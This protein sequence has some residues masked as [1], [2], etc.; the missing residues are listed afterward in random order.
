MITGT[1]A[2]GFEYSVNPGIVYDAKYIKA[3][4]KLRDKKSDDNARAE[5]VFSMIDAVFSNDDEQIERLM[6]HLAIQSPTG[7]T[8]VRALIREV[9]EIVEAIMEADDGAKK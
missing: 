2:S 7:R 3:S 6:Q 1:T 4:V 5:A 9:N 8:D